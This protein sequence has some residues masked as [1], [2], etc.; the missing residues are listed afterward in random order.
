MRYVVLPD[1]RHAAVFGAGHLLAFEI[2]N[3]HSKNI[4]L[5][6]TRMPSNVF[7]AQRQIRSLRDRW[8]FLKEFVNRHTQFRSNTGSLASADDRSRSVNS[9]DLRL[10]DRKQTPVESKCGQK[11]RSITTI[12]SS[13]NCLRHDSSLVVL[14]MSPPP[15]IRITPDRIDSLD[16]KSTHSSF[17]A[18]SEKSDVARSLRACRR[19]GSTFSPNCARAAVGS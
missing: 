7:G 6:T 2:S 1:G 9:L 11:A 18:R 14:G 3:E 13:L 19:S 10:E 16:T 17:V 12:I 15:K 8:H 4:S 5:I